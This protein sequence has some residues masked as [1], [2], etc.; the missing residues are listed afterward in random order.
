MK[1]THKYYGILDYMPRW[2]YTIIVLAAILW[3]TLGKIP[4]IDSDIPIWEHADKIVH[5]FMFGVLFLAA[6]FD[7]SRIRPLE[8]PSIKSP[9]MPTV[10]A[11]TALAGA[12]IELLQ[13]YFYRSCDAA[14]FFADVAG[15]LL[16]WLMIPLLFRRC[17]NSR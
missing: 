11:W 17:K 8:I 5:A 16:A 2:G 9:Y 1:K 13:P 14:D 6:T 7:H 4:R 3:L 10:F 15:I 12:V